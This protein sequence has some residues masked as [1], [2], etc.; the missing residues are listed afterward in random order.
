MQRSVSDSGS[1]SWFDSVGGTWTE[2]YGGSDKLAYDSTNSQ[3]IL[4]DSSG[5]QSTFYDFTGGVLA[6]KIKSVSDAG[7]NVTNYS[8]NG[9]GQPTLIVNSATSGTVTTKE[10]LAYSYLASP[11]PNAGKVGS[12]TWQTKTYDTSLGQSDSSV[13]YSIVKETDYTYY[14][15]GDS[16]GS[17]GDLEMAQT[18]DPSG[19][20]IDTQFNRYYISGDSDTHGYVGALKYEFGT[21]A[22]ARLVE[23]LT[24]GATP[25]TA[26]DAQVAPYADH[27]YQYNSNHQVT[28]DVVGGAGGNSSG[29]QG[30]DSLSYTDSGNATGY[31]YW[32]RKTT[33]TLPDGTTQYH[34]FN[35]YGE[36]LLS[37][38][39]DTSGNLWGTFT[40]YDD[41]GRVI[42]SANPSAVN[43]PSLSTIEQ[44]PDLLNE[45]GGNYEYLNDST[46]LVTTTSYYSGTSTATSTTAGSAAG[47]ES[48]TYIQDGE[49]GTPV[50][51]E[52]WQYYAFSAGNTTTYPVATDTTYGNTNGTDT[53]TTRY[54]YTLY[55]GTVQPK[56]ETVTLP[57][58][59]TGQNGPNTTDAQSTFYDTYGRPI[60]TKDADGHVNYT[61]YDMATGATTQT[62]TDV[63]YSSLTSDQKSSFD[64]TGWTD[65]TGGLN[66]VTNYE[67]DNQGRT[68]KEVSPHGNVTY[69]VYDDANHETRVYSG[70]QSTT[71]TASAA[72]STTTLI[73][74]SLIGA[75]GAYIGQTLLITGGTDSGQST[76]ITGYDAST[77]TLTFSPAFTSA[78]STSSTFVMAGATGPIEVSR[79]YDA[80]A[81]SGDFSYDETLT[82][83]AAASIDSTGAP[84]GQETISSSNITSLSRQFMN[85]AGQVAW[86]DVY[87]NLSGIT[88]SQAVGADGDGN[89][90]DLGTEGTNYYRTTTSYDSAG[91]A[92]RVVSATGTITRTVYDALGRTVSEWEGTCDTP[93]SGT[94]TPTNNGGSSNMIEI[95]DNQ[96]DGGG[97]GDSNL[98]QVTQHPANS[99]PDRVTQY[100]YDWRGRQVVEKDGVQSSESD[101]THRPITYTVYDNLGEVTE[102]DRYDGDGVTLSSLGSTAGVP[103][104]P[105]SSLLRAKAITSYDPDGNVL[106]INNL[107]TSSQSEL[108][109][110]NSAS[111]GDDATAYDGLN[112]LTSY[113][114]GTLSATTNNGS[115]L[116]TSL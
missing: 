100:L 32:N 111:S 46:G 73:C 27:Y 84:T 63:T 43:I 82:T 58:I 53:R 83:S 113:E 98:T 42:L 15:T 97:V 101:G 10:A 44:Y 37:V 54:S 39:E 102:S 62:I 114:R 85:A 95:V 16:G 2:R 25:A 22:Y 66:L 8:Y 115:T 40:E 71:G 92:D 28:G 70:W 72:A 61:A 107:V 112:R 55:S 94:W 30:T 1:L 35:A 109:H 80:S 59:S 65:P 86:S 38:T 106:Y 79:E 52:S 93:A 5:N 47:Y 91:R 77:H 3:F 67:V 21:S 110:A 29:G 50:E 23:S 45:S 104:A 19:N 64:L 33:E 89:P 7:G 41:E 60:W 9:S 13:S 34:Y 87:F 56:L 116:D 90:A 75:N 74:S 69:T 12:I 18:K 26:T 103:N 81:D 99:Q 48:A 11:D 20:V 36:E 4:T 14:N 88:Y 57:T 96:Y 78:T 108:F 31:N 105:S 6:G 76:V 51:Q 68:I 24:G 17:L 49:T